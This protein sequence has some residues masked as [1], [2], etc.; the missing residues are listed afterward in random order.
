MTTQRWFQE[1]SRT[2]EDLRPDATPRTEKVCSG[3]RKHPGT[4]AE[5]SKHA[6][7]GA[8]QVSLSRWRRRFASQADAKE[9]HG[10]VREMNPDGDQPWTLLLAYK[11]VLVEG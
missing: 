11:P 2:E 10:K 6:S 5:I 3:L 9:F 8:A 7:K 1:H 4:W